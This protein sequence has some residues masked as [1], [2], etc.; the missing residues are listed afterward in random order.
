MSIT[1]ISALCLLRRG[2]RSLMAKRFGGS[3]RDAGRRH[4]SPGRTSRSNHGPSARSMWPKAPPHPYPSHP[5]C[6]HVLTQHTPLPHIHTHTHTQTRGA[7]DGIQ[8]GRNGRDGVD[9]NILGVVS[10]FCVIIVPFDSII[11]YIFGVLWMCFQCWR[12]GREWAAAEL[13]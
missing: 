12:P 11:M 8:S 3:S 1:R 7:K 6:T 9:K 4:P 13:V 5:K 10:F 2:R